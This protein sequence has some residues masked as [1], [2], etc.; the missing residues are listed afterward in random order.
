M[1][2]PGL[3]R[4]LVGPEAAGKRL[5]QGGAQLFGLSRRQTRALVEEGLVWLNGRCCRVAARVLSLGDVVDLLPPAQPTHPPT[6]P[7]PPLPILHE[8]GFLVAVDKPAGMLTQPGQERLVGELA[9]I[10]HL[11]LQLAY[12][13]GH[14]LE[15]LPVHRLDRVA[16]GLL[17]FAKHHDAAAA[18]SQAFAQ[19]QVEKV[20]LAVVTGRPQNQ[21][22]VAAPVAPDP[23]LPGRFRVAASGKKAL[24]RF[25]VLARQ[26]RFALVELRP[27]TGRSHQL[28][29]HLA[30]IGCPIVG[31][32]LYGS[33]FPAPRPLLHAWRLRLPHPKDG[34]PLPLEAPLPADLIG[35]CREYELALPEGAMAAVTASPL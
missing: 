31:D 21:G 35:F 34:H 33:H 18:L 28:R 11:S 23:L 2:S 30:A 25:R 3:W 8:D 12:R 32:S 27:A 29:V 14:R 1:A 24:T 26:D 19:Q 15:L 20:Y 4:Y 6:P 9:A 22:T 13:E 16:S 10:E 5:D 17:L 7:P